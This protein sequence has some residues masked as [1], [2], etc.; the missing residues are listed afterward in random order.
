MCSSDLIGLPDQRG[1][2]FHRTP[3]DMDD[4]GAALA[5]IASDMGAGETEVIAQQMH[6]QRS[7]FDIG[8]NRLAVDGQLHFGHSDLPQ[9]FAL[10]VFNYSN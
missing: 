7:V 8:R 9:L 6:E 1:A 10:C 5:G 4:A 3:I 2:G